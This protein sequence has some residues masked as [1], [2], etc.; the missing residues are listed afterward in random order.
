[1][2][3]I[4]IST[5]LPTKPA[6]S[7]IGI[8]I[9][10]PP[11]AVCGRLLIVWAWADPLTVDGFVPHASAKLID[12]VA[13]K[14]GFA[15]A[16][17]SVN[18][19]V[20][21]AG[22]VRFPN[23]ERHNSSSA[24]ARAGEAE[25]KRTQR[26]DMVAAQKP[27]KPPEACPEKCPDNSRTIVRTRGEERRSEP[28]KPPD[29]GGGDYLDHTEG[30]PATVMPVSLGSSEAFVTCW[31]R[32]WLPYLI[33]RKGGRR[34]AIMTLERQLQTCVRLGPHRAIAALESA[35]EKEWAA[36]DE[37]AKVVSQAGAGRPWDNAPDDWKAYWRETYPPENF[38]DAPRYE[39]GDWSD[40]PSDHR[41][42]IWEGL[43]KQ[44]RR[45]A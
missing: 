35:I 2:S 17:Q 22:G 13:G 9:N 43:Q 29:R 21:E 19:L 20:C 8:E 4:K 16:M 42:M 26:A 40:V 38:P 44:K 15:A 37:Q 14:R 30:R 33:E 31:E 18:W 12:R 5:N 3:W 7:A 28:P 41:K 32:K 27:D 1:M 23:W 6:V 11:H 36:P 39:D 25:R 45:S 10:E 34:P 24:K